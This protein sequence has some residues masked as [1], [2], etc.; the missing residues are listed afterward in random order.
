[1]TGMAY[2]HTPAS[3]TERQQL[4]G[5]VVALLLATVCMLAL[6]MTA[7]GSVLSGV[8]LGLLSVGFFVI[9]TISIG[10]SDSKRI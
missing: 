10:T 4:A 7:P 6:A 3:M 9:G 8:V 2:S 1:M 5:G